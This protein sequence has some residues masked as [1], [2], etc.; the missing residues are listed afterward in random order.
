LR[1]RRAPAPLAVA[2]ASTAWPA[3]RRPRLK[4]RASDCRLRREGSAPW[5]QKASTRSAG[6]SA[7]Q[8][9]STVRP[10]RK[11]TPDQACLTLKRMRSIDHSSSARS[12]K[13]GIFGGRNPCLVYYLPFIMNG[14]GACRSAAAPHSARS[15]SPICWSRCRW[16][17]DFSARRVTAVGIHIWF[18]RSNGHEI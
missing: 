5:F 1:R 17:A 9:C 18:M 8:A 4:R 6:G 15:G 14:L 3:R 11:A 10:G 2:A 13:G 7:P 12:T 16:I